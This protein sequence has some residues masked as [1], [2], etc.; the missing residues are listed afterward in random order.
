VLWEA[1]VGNVVVFDAERF[2]DDLGSLIAIIALNGLAKL[3]PF[4]VKSRTPL[5]SR[6]PIMR[7]PSCLISCIQPWPAGGSLASRGKHGSMARE[8]L[9]IE[10]GTRLI[11][12]RIDMMPRSGVES[13][14]HARP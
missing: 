7:K 6:C 3:Y 12:I 8:R 13:G 11:A 14:R 5:S 9:R 10:A 2:L 4:R 1:I